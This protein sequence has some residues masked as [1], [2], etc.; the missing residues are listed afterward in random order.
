MSQAANDLSQAR[1][2]PQ[3]AP[4]T[5]RELAATL[6]APGTRDERAGL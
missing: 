2:D 4:R 5:L 6:I 3:V 1:T